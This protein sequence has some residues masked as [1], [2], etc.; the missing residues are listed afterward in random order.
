MQKDWLTRWTGWASISR[1]VGILAGLI[2]LAMAGR[3]LVA[4]RTQEATQR[5]LAT[6]SKEKAVL[7]EAGIEKARYEAKVIVHSEA[8]MAHEEQAADYERR[9]AVAKARVARLRSGE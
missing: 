8:A 7:A 3:K 9:V 2:A 6:E 4:H 5:K 1:I